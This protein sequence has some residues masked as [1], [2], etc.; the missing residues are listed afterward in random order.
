[1]PLLEDATLVVLDTET[2]GMSP[3]AGH[4]LVEVA[5]V[6]IENG[7]L[8][9]SWSSLVH[10]GRPILPDAV[11]IHGITDAMVSGAPGPDVV[12]RDLASACGNCTLVFHNAAFDLPFIAAMLRAAGA[13][14][15]YNPVVD[16]LGLARGLLPLKSHSL[17]ALAAHFGLETEVAHRAL[18]DAMTTAR[19]FLI[20]AA[21]W[22]AERGIR[23]L[24]ELAAASQDALRVPRPAPALEEV[25]R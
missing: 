21:R 16:T 8:A 22:E 7:T 12:A 10:P 19:L 3:L 15:L 2:T 25:A 17:Q 24:P 13:P 11:A 23:S 9:G 14:P 18:G 5:R 20:L 1:M 4:S 6:S